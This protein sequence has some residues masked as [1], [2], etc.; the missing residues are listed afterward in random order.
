MC[1]KIASTIFVRFFSSGKSIK[2]ILVITLLLF[3]KCPVFSVYWAV[4]GNDLIIGSCHRLHA[5]TIRSRCLIHLIYEIIV[6]LENVG[7]FL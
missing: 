4:C 5:E 2:L 1:S 7:I 6:F 3:K